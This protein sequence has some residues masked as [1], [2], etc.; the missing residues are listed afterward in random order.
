MYRIEL[1]FCRDSRKNV[2]HL[3]NRLDCFY[4]TC[5]KPHTVIYAIR[6]S[7]SY[8]IRASLV[9]PTIFLIKSVLSYFGLVW[10][11]HYAFC[12]LGAKFYNAL[13]LHAFSKSLFR[14]TINLRINYG[15][16]FTFSFCFSIF[17][18]NKRT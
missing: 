9:S 12:L 17:D 5:S 11:P 8:I 6:L 18:R 1:I 4:G 2:L 10:E 15:E 14:G 7:G 3:M 16:V 13:S